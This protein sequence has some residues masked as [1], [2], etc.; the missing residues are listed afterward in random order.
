MGANIAFSV[1]TGLGI[2]CAITP[3]AWHWK[4]RNV[5]ALCLIFWVTLSNTIYFINSLIWHGNIWTEWS[6]TVW[7][8]IVVK[9]FTGNDVGTTGAA[10]AIER[11]LARVMD[12]N[13]PARLTSAQQKRYMWE[14]IALSFG[15]PI[16]LMAT[17][18]IYQPNRY[19]L[20]QYQGC[21][22]SA[23]PSWPTIPLRYIW[24]PIF[25]FMGAYYACVVLYRYFKRRRDFGTI[26][27]NSGTG[28]TT[29]RFVRLILFSS[30]YI[31]AFLPLSLYIFIQNVRRPLLSYSWDAV[32]EGWNTYTRISGS[33][34]D[35]GT[36]QKWIP[37]TAAILLFL[38]FGLGTDA[39]NMYRDWLIAAV[40]AMGLNRFFPGLMRSA[41]RLGS[42]VMMSITD[43][44]GGADADGK[45]KDLTKMRKYGQGDVEVRIDPV[46]T[47][48]SDSTH[49]SR[50]PPMHMKQS[51]F[52]QVDSIHPHHSS[53]A[54]ERT[55]T[56]TNSVYAEERRPS[57]FDFAV[58]GG[59][60][61]KVDI[62][63]TSSQK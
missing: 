57:D 3:A 48:E 51:Y 35:A 5:P 17:H 20:I 50:T 2:V 16:I 25:A 53:L 8:D 54:A 11:Y 27:R 47:F 15:M 62:R 58:A 40:K 32:H 33:V 42:T 45:E 49:V 36:V 60:R 6:G 10:V 44:R 13:T 46:E 26:L 39:M 22:A 7:C 12:P 37:P 28:L 63:Q 18:Y 14:D 24:N 29:A 31:A 34:A 55:G 21:A 19:V 30:L 61:V 4:N 56:V 43:S 23:D 9:I 1:L 59:I 41:K 52:E 38:V